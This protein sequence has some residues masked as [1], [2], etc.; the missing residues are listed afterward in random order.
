LLQLLLLLLLLCAILIHRRLQP[1][2]HNSRALPGGP[3]AAFD[4][5][6]G[7]FR[8]SQASV[9]QQQKHLLL[10]CISSTVTVPCPATGRIRAAVAAA[11]RAAARACCR[12]VLLSLPAA[13]PLLLLFGSWGSKQRGSQVLAWWPVNVDAGLLLLLL[14][15]LLGGLLLLL[16][17]LVWV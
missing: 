5:E 11:A 3:A 10:S 13:P 12:I 1:R 4:M 8:A 15:P 9:V 6:S 14:L 16:L 7:A 17:L 2:L